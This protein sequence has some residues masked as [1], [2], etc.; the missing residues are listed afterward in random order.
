MN[1][2]IPPLTE[3]K[4]SQFEPQSVGCKIP[5]AELEGLLGRCLTDHS[6]QESE[7]LPS[8]CQGIGSD[9]SLQPSGVPNV[10][11]A[12][13]TDFFYPLVEDPY[14]M[15]KIGAANVLS[16][17]YAAGITSCTNV[18]MILAGSSDMPLE[19]RRIVLELMIR[20]F[21]DQV[22]KAGSKVTGGQTIFNPWPM[23]GGTAMSVVSKHELFQLSESQVGDILV[24]TK[25]LGTQVAVNLHQWLVSK[26]DLWKQVE[27]VIHED[28]VLWAYDVATESMQRLNRTAA[29]LMKKYNAHAATDVTGF[30]ILGHA[31]NL[32]RQQR[33]H[34]SFVLECLPCIK[35]MAK[36]DRCVKQGDRFQL[37]RGLSAETSGGL[38]IALPVDSV[39]SFLNEIY[40][41]EGWKSFVVG[42]VLDGN[43]DAFVKDP[44]EIFDVE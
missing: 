42:R 15:G 12:S 5:Q 13:T 27:G 8:F 30:G 38:L 2:C 3:P 14:V 32:A 17:L 6:C 16:D 41:E 21:S 23:I 7:P 24:L 33:R 31:R 29:T 35:G 34:V 36:V 18:L 10:F 37:C 22:E 19:E 40:L 39:E 26:P 25:P 28:E 44:I 20:G 1:N 4:T 43:R 9:C 11:L